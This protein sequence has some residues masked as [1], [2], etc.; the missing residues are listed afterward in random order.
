[1]NTKVSIKTQ[2]PFSNNKHTQT[3]L[4]DYHNNKKNSSYILIGINKTNT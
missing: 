4:P 1:M 2:W 3:L